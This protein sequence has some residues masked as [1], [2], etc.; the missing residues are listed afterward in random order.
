MRR[1]VIKVGTAVLTDSGNLAKKRLEALVELICELHLK[2]EIILVSSGAVASG[3]A[4]LQLDKKVVSNRQALASIGQP[5]LMRIYKSVFEKHN[6]KVAQ[7]LLTADDFDSIKRTKHAKNAIE[8]LLN[9]KVIPIINENDVTATEELVFGDNDR[10]SA[11]TTLFFDADMLIILTDIDGYYDK[12]PRMFSDAK[13]LSLVKELSESE[14]EIDAN[15]NSDF[16]TGG[17]V[18]KLKAGDFLLKNGKEMFLT[19]GFDLK[20]VRSFLIDKKQIGGT[21]FS[22]KE[23]L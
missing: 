22:K 23:I 3:Y 7:L 15:P 13:I 10:L 1:I 16:A 12:N 14:L 19:S 11:A 20:Y 2:Y 4:E 5:A 17:I 9:Y 21:L 8:V 6:I 18:T